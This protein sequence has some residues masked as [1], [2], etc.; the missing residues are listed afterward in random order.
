MVAGV[1]LAMSVPEV[2][3][4]GMADVAMVRAPTVELL[5]RYSRVPEAGDPEDTERLVTSL[6]LMSERNF[7][8][9]ARRDSRREEYDALAARLARV[10]Q[11]AFGLTGE[12]VR[13]G[14][15]PTSRRR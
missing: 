7:Y 5:R 8:H 15:R 4:Q 9:L 3:E 10:W 13:P 11:R 12:E 2:Y 14:G 6:I 1:E